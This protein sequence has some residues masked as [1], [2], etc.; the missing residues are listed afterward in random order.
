MNPTLYLV[1]GS[2]RHTICEHKYIELLIRVMCLESGDTQDEYT[3]TAIEVE[4]K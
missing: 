3:A 4:V 2:S 1:S